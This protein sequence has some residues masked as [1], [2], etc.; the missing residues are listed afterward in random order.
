MRQQEKAKQVAP[1]PLESSYSLVLN[2]QNLLEKVRTYACVRAEAEAGWQVPDL[3]ARWVE[4]GGGSWQAFLPQDALG[5]SA[6]AGPMQE[7]RREEL[8]R[9]WDAA[10]QRLLR[11]PHAVFWSHLL[12]DASLP[13]FLCS[14]LRY[15]PRP[16]EVR[17][18]FPG[19]P[20]L[21]QW[22]TRGSRRRRSGSCGSSRASGR[23]S[24]RC[25]GCTSACCASSCASPALART[26]ATSCP[27]TSGPVRSTRRRHLLRPLLVRVCGT[28]ES[29]EG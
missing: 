4:G 13:A 15:F 26:P 5:G 1:V 16:Y 21:L 28:G 6:E 25:C 29:E 23:R 7:A 3:S 20:W 8:L 10:L 12:Y 11:A 2:Q 27:P 14:F 17:L 22:L 24:G 19:S 9:V 18:S